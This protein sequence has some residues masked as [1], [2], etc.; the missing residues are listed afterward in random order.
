MTA[1]ARG[2]GAFATL[3]NWQIFTVCVLVW[4]TTWYA[5]TLQLRHAT[6]EAGVALRFALAGAAVLAWCAW[7]GVSLRFPW[8]VHARLAAQGVF[9]YSLSYLG[10]YHAE[11]YIASGLVA[12]VSSASP[13]LNALGAHWLWRAPLG[14]RFVTG[15][16]LAMSGVALIFLPEV[17]HATQGAATLRGVGITLLGLALSVSGNLLAT[18]NARES[19]PLWPSMGFGMLWGSACSFAV[20]LLTGQTLH[21]PQDPQWW[22]SLLYLALAGSVLTFAGY[23]TLLQRI[24]PGRASTIGVMTPVLALCVSVAFE[25]YRPGLAALAGAALA[26]AGNFWMLR[27]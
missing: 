21:W 20:L 22:G 8:R 11:Q 26:V 5:I 23:L 16:L 3:A 1:A 4:S 13:L 25:G 15:A 9:M 7:R 6:P 24:G 2:P 18:R 10:Y 12:V 19:L 27:R 17:Q 14:V